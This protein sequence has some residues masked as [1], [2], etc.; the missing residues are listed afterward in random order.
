MKI[1]FSDS[2][3]LIGIL[4]ECQRIAG[5]IMNNSL[6][7]A[8]SN[9]YNQIYCFCGIMAMAIKTKLSEKE[10]NQNQKIVIK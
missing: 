5:Q 10:I 8:E 9:K 6:T 7:V 1:D 3:T 4:A 2:N